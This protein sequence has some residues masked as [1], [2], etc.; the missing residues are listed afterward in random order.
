VAQLDVDDRRFER[1]RTLLRE[2]LELSTT[3]GDRRMIVRCLERLAYLA[4][5]RRRFR[6]AVRLVDAASSLR[7]AAGLPRAQ[8]ERKA[9]K[10]W[11]EPAELSL[12]PAVRDQLGREG[13]AMALETVLTYAV[14]SSVNES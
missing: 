14:E 12:D 6:R 4:T 1:A 9:L 2:A 8:V 3:L 5:A 13:A 7:A 10:R 11:L